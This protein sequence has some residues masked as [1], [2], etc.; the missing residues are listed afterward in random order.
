M[1][2]G[3]DAATEYGTVVL[4]DDARVRDDHYAAVAARAYQAS[5]A[6]AKAN[7][8]LRQVVVSE[9]RASFALD[10]LAPRFDYRVAALCKRQARYDDAT[11]RLA[12]DID[13]FPERLRAKYDGARRC[14]A[15]SAC[16]RLA[17]RAFALDQQANARV[18]KLRTRGI[19]DAVHHFVAREKNERPSIRRIE[20]VA[21]HIRKRIGISDRIRRGI[22]HRARCEHKRLAKIVERTRRHERLDAFRAAQPLDHVAEIAADPQ[23]SGREYDRILLVVE[24]ILQI[25][26]NRERRRH[27]ARIRLPLLRVDVLDPICMGRLGAGEDEARSGDERNELLGAA[28]DLHRKVRVDLDA[29]LVLVFGEDI[30][31]TMEEIDDCRHCA[32]E[33]RLCRD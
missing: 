22:R 4:G 11:E 23:R 7:D 32:F 18:L 33:L 19:R 5:K 21:H 12:R 28:I 17:G 24:H 29:V 8:R 1:G 15:Q 14:V 6:L 13:A 9:A 2:G 25:L 16:H 26:R 10:F 20:E 3:G 27:K 31:H 30:A